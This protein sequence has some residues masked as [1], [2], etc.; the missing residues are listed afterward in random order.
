MVVERQQVDASAIQPLDDFVFGIEIVGLV[1]KVETG[2]RRELR[3]QHFDRLEQQS[4]M[5]AASQTRLPGPR[6]GM[7]KRRDTVADGLPVAFCQ[8]DIHREIDTGTGHQLPLEGIAVQ[9]DDA[10]QHQ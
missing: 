4:G 6:H 7:I 1:A 3:P 8:R 5:V 2:V 10:R 9:I